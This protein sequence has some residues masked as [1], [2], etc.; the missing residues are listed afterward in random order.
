[1]NKRTLT[2]IGVATLAGIALLLV[3]SGLLPLTTQGP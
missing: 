1:M 2:I 3:L